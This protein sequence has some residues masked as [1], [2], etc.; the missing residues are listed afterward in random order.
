[1]RAAMRVLAID[2]GYD[3]LGMAVLEGNASKPVYVWSACVTP[4]KGA[5]SERLSEVFDAISEALAEYAPD[6]LA[7]EKLFF[8]TN[9]KTALG[10]AEA[11]GSVLAAAGKARVEVIEYS[12]QEV[13]L[14]VTGYGAADKAAVAHMIPLLITLPQKKR[15]DDEID[16]I[17]LAIAA[18]SHS[19][20]LSPKKS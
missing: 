14:A 16:A 9:V 4:R 8:S 13:K 18:L 1:M 7:I 17:A 6:A 12:P 15:L 11:R 10:V 3:R 5:P 20:H 2:P 19:S